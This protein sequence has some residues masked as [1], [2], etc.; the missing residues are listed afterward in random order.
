MEARAL[1]GQVAVVTG[2]GRGIGREVVLSLARD[3]AYVVVNY[4]E[5]RRAAEET[6]R[7]VI[8][9]GGRSAID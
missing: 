7:E 3:G 1:A 2:G 8:E 6:V 9:G 5:N 4:R